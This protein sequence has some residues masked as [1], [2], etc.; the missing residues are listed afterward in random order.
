M[1]ERRKRRH[2]KRITSRARRALGRYARVQGPASLFAATSWPK[3]GA[4]RPSTASNGLQRENYRFHDTLPA[5][6]PELAPTGL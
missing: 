6:W 5:K 4:K 3:T 1:I 2:F